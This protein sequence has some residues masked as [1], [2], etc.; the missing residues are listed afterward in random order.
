MNFKVKN[1]NVGDYLPKFQ[2]GGE[3]PAEGAPVEGAP[4]PEKQGG[5]PMQ[6]LLEGAAQALQ[7]QD[8]NLAMQVCDALMQLAQGGGGEQPAPA[9]EP[10]YKRG[11]RLVRTIRK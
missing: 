8:C 5:D 6:M 7:N 3:M 1:F 9:E 2:E 4:A 10:V 11:G